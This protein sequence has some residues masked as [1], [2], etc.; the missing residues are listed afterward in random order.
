MKHTP[1]PRSPD[2]IEEIASRLR[3]EQPKPVIAPFPDPV[4]ED[5]DERRVIV[6]DFT[7]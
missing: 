4:G 5:R 6:W 2:S 1:I 7:L 3:A